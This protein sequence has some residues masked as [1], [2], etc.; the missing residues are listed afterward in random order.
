MKGLT[1]K[2]ISIGWDSPPDDLADEDGT[3]RNYM[4]YIHY[5]KLTRRSQDDTVGAFAITSSDKAGFFFRRL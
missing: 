5:Y 3:E 1:W 2:S 4:E